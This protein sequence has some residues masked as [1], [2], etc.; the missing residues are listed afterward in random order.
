MRLIR[1]GIWIMDQH[2]VTKTARNNICLAWTG[3]DRH[4]AG[5]RSLDPLENPDAMLLD[6][7]SKCVQWLYR[8]FFV[9]FCFRAMAWKGA[10]GGVLLLYGCFNAHLG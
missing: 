5:G 9:K 10:L 4:E 3:M 7:A 6:L 1:D 8:A 2:W